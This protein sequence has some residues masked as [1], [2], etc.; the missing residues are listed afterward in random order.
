[1]NESII[2]FAQ[3]LGVEVCCLSEASGYV[4]FVSFLETG[5]VLERVKVTRSYLT[6]RQRATVSA[7][8]RARSRG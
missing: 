8:A 7:R 2:Y 3:A 5:T 4:R 6:V 1:M